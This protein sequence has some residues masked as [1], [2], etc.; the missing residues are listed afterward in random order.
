MLGQEILVDTCMY[1]YYDRLSDAAQ[2]LV[3]GISSQE[4]HIPGSNYVL[5]S[6]KNKFRGI[7]VIGNYTLSSNFTMK[8]TLYANRK[9]EMRA[10][11]INRTA[12]LVPCHLGYWYYSKS[13][14]C[15]CHNASGI[16]FCSGSSSSTIK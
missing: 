7:K 2:F 15:E 11:S 10:I 9:S 14:S 8:F 5:I 3:T 4:F 1:D 13:L 12:Q 16:V 6:C